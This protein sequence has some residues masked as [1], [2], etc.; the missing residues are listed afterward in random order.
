MGCTAQYYYSAR[1]L[2]NPALP[3]PVANDLPPP[4]LPCAIP[5]ASVSKD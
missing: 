3:P 4:A 1:C 5:S 2:G